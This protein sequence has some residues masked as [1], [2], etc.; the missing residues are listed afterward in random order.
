M[1][2]AQLLPFPDM[3]KEEGKDNLPR[4]TKVYRSKEYIEENSIPEPNSGCWIWLGTVDGKGYG[5]TAGKKRYGHQIASRYSYDAYKGSPDG[6]QV[7]HKC[8]NPPCVNPDHL[9]LGTA[10]D[11]YDDMVRKGRKVV[12]YVRGE[13]HGKSKLT[14]DDVRWIRANYEP[15]VRGKTCNALAKKLGVHERT[16]DSVIRGHSW[17][18]LK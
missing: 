7:C 10:K 4:G 17:G 15:F 2:Q 6:M 18:H 1:K 3:K 8:D 16:V 12:V 5:V 13:R 11:N 14:E 9:F